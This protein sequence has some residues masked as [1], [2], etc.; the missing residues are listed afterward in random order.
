MAARTEHSPPV[1]RPAAARRRGQ[2]GT[3]SPHRRRS[4]R[5]TAARRRGQSGTASLEMV[6]VVPVL[7]LLAVF[8]LWAGRVGRVRL[9]AD[10]AAG[11]AA[12]AAALCCEDGAGGAAA[13][14]VLVED[15]LAAR[16]SLEFLC[17]GGVRPGADPHTGSGPPEFVQERWLDFERAGAEADGMGVLVVRFTCESDGALVPLRGVLPT[18]TI[19]GQA[20]EVVISSSLHESPGG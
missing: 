12:T 9:V 18:A 8:V 6:M 1:G 2:P 11:E 10:L 14:E 13:R 3:A 15:L 4:R 16:P 17:V 7:V 20:S 5:L 19:E